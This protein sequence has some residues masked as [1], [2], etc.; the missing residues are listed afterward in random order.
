MTCHKKDRGGGAGS[1]YTGQGITSM[2]LAHP[3][4]AACV[5]QR[6]EGVEEMADRKLGG[7]AGDFSIL[8]R[9]S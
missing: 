4:L 8:P 1:Q 3:P 9:P 2:S 6:L 7:P 5:P